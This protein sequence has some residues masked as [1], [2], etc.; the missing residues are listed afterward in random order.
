MEQG[1]L[2]KGT[3]GRRAIYSLSAEELWP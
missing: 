1:R 3:E 2:A